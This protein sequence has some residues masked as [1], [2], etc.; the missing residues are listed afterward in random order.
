MARP[1]D[2]L[3]EL[4]CSIYMRVARAEPPGPPIYPD[5]EPVIRTPVFRFCRECNTGTE[6]RVYDWIDEGIETE[7]CSVCE[8]TK[9]ISP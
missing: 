4:L 8:T 9:V 2:L 7:E 6:H 1:L 5:R 3:G